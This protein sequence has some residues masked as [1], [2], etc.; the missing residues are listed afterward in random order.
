MATD[1]FSTSNVD[2][3][4]TAAL[5]GS[6]LPASFRFAVGE[7]VTEGAELVEFVK[8]AQ[9]ATTE[10]VGLVPLCT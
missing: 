2:A 7:Q 4:T 5:A 3:A 1:V 9:A 10:R 6:N 8:A